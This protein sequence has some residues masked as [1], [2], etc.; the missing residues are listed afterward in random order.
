MSSKFIC[1]TSLIW[2][3]TI[4]LNIS[5][6]ESSLINLPILSLQDMFIR[7]TIYP[8]AAYMRQ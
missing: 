7:L 1:E 8:S 2:F 5:I 3:D 6:T 4:S